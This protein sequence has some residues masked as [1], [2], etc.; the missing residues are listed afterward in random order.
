VGETVTVEFVRRLRD[1]M[2]FASVDALRSQ[3]E[4]DRADALRAL[5]AQDGPVNL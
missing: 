3:L 2:P 5:T 1:V 4:R